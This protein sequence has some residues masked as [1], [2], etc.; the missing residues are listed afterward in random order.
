MV[1]VEN[2]T[3]F[4]PLEVVEPKLAPPTTKLLCIATIGLVCVGVGDVFLADDDDDET[5]IGRA[6]LTT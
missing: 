5:K 2:L 1:G 6:L 4:E 3:V